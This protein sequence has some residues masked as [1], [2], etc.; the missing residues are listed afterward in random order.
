M[1]WGKEKSELLTGGRRENPERKNSG[2]GI[3]G[4]RHDRSVFFPAV[5]W[6]ESRGRRID[7]VFWGLEVGPFKKTKNAYK[8]DDSRTKRWKPKLSSGSHTT[9]KARRMRGKR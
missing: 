6:K 2:H 8:R 9:K 5:Q 7:G 3:G 4:R 1:R